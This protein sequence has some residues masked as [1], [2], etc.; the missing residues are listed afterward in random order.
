METIGDAY[1][2]VSG[3]PTRNGD[4]H[5]EQ[6]CLC[7]LALLQNVQGNF[8]IHHRPQEQLKDAVQTLRP[9]FESI[10]S[11]KVL[12]NHNAAWYSLSR[13]KLRIGIH[14]GPCVA[15]VVGKKMPR[16]C[17]FGDTV[18]TSNRME[19]SGLRKIVKFIFNNCS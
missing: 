4:H 7:A 12:K 3:L 2:L 10:S 18:N 6:I 9:L 1:M 15:G 11:C 16:Y 13:E 14:S 19:S 8:K 5:V 17:L